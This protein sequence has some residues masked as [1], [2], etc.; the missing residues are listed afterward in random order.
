[1]AKDEEYGWVVER[2]SQAAPEY[3]S[4]HLGEWTWTSDHLVALRFARE[5]DAKRVRAVMEANGN[6]GLRV[7]EHIWS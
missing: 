7:A 5:G 3:L 6:S 4:A 2:A 1:M